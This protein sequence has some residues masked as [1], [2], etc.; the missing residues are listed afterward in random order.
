MDQTSKY[1]FFQI[2]PGIMLFFRALSLGKILEELGL[3]RKISLWREGRYSAG[4]AE[5]VAGNC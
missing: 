5:G 3:S 1:L 2:L 4:V